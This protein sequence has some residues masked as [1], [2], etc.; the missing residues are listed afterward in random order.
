MTAHLVA[1]GKKLAGGAG[2][3]AVTAA[4][5]ATLL[6]S[7]PAQAT[8]PPDLTDIRP[9][10]A[11][12]QPYGTVVHPLGT[13]ERD[14]PYVIGKPVHYLPRGSQ[15]N[16]KCLVSAQDSPLGHVWYR[17]RDRD[18]WIPAQ[19]VDLA[20]QLSTCTTAERP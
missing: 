18:T 9:I 17:L 3:C 4:F 20:G 5:G 8:E 13:Y 12:T 14:H 10:T 6:G 16:L 11:P 7:A 2:A 19:H 1:R 15:V